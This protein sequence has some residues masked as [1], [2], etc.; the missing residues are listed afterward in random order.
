MRWSFCARAGADAFRRSS[1][2]ESVSDSERTSKAL[3][4]TDPKTRIRETDTACAATLIASVL[5]FAF[6]SPIEAQTVSLLGEAQNFAI[7]GDSTVTSTGPTS[8]VGN[9]GV[10][11]GSAITGF[12]PGVVTQGTL[13]TGDALAAQAQ[14]D[15]L[16]AY[17]ILAGEPSP[18]NNLTGHP[19]P[20]ANNLRGQNLGGLTLT[21]GVYRFDSSAQLT[22]ALS[23]NNTG[24]PTGTFIFQIGFASSPPAGR[25]W[26]GSANN[27]WSG[28]NWSPD[29][30][31]ATSSNLL[32]GTDVVF[33][34]TGI[35]A[36]N[37]N[38]V[39]DVNETISSLTVDDATAVTIAGPNT[40]TITGTGVGSGITINSGAG[41]TTIN[42]NLQLTGLSKAITVNNTAGLVINGIVGGTIGLTKAGTGLLTL[43]GLN[44]YSGGTNIN[45]GILAVNSDANLGT[46]PL[47]F[48]GGTLEALAVVGG[49]GITSS[50]AITL[51]G[52]GGTFQADISTTSTLS[53][54]ISGTG[55]FTKTGTGTL[56]LTG[57]NT[58]NGG[59]VLNAGTLNV[60]GTQALGLGNV[61]VNGGTLDFLGGSTAANSAI[62]NNAGFTIFNNTSTA[63]NAT[64]T[65]N[66]GG[67][68][69]F[70]SASM[71]GN[72]NFITNAGGK[73]DISRL[74]SGGTTAGSIEGAGTYFLG[75]K[76]L[77]V[78]SNLSTQVS[79]TIA[80]GGIGRGT[81]GALIKVGTGTLTLTGTNTYS[82]GT[83][84]NGGTL[85]VDNDANLGTGPLSFNGGTL[86]AL[87]IGGGGGITSSKAITLDGGGGTFQADIS[88]TSTLSG[89]I[90]G[91]GAFTKTGTGTLTLTGANTYN[92]GTVLNAGTLNVGGTQALG[93]GDVVVNGGT[94]LFQGGSTAAN[95]AITNNVG[96]TIFSD[97]STAGNAT[98]TTNNGGSTLFIRAS[99]GGNANFITNAG[100]KV[101]ISGL[102]SGGTTA[103]S[104]EGAG[105]YFLG[106]KTLTVGSNLS[107]QV[108]GTIADGGI[109]RGT[110]GALIKV[111]TGT[112][113]LT[114]TNTYSGGTSFNGGTLAVDND[115]NLGTGPLSFNGGALEALAFG[116]G[117]TSS[118]AISSM[119]GAARFQPI[120]APLRL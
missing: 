12:P 17:M 106:S 69:L 36:Q 3:S 107:T 83:S 51:D 25:F 78:G 29:A 43:T 89:T 118:K 13:H 96:F 47:S 15:A 32:S 111:G 54:T 8:I 93:L 63:G 53:G 73:V 10:S 37:Q 81:G 56:T 35:Q 9:I 30:T 84:F 109:R 110:G 97:T 116:G 104:I 45:G 7:L 67:S 77:T 85:A 57:A 62:T 82:G 27:L 65:T 26:N 39:L 108:S 33:S 44:T 90:S 49:G 14:A 5:L 38:T 55:A 88:T 98:I 40:L 95:S 64:I 75:S 60:G 92:G 86:E 112:L 91:R 68:T 102:S 103:G 94:L 6:F 76:T 50:K 119:A 52:G 19:S 87:A 70:I 71:G 59:T 101:D 80:D 34:V 23:L 18:D 79:G 16:T 22:G 48:N 74:S 66:N 4:H 21:P 120:P 113:T 114:G 1:S 41:L 99:M 105:T 2:C 31:G 61:V 28:M 42:S 115:A 58:Y 11:P 24:N 20:P 72:A 46:G 100:G 117:I